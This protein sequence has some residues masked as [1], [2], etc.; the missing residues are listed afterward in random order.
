MAILSYRW[1]YWSI[2]F[3]CSPW[4]TS[5]TPVIGTGRGG[6]WRCRWCICSGWSERLHCLPISLLFSLLDPSRF[7][8]LDCCPGCK[9]LPHSVREC[10]L[11]PWSSVAAEHHWG[12]HLNPRRSHLL[13]SLYTAH[14][15]RQLSGPA[16][17][18]TSFQTCHYSFSCS[19]ICLIF[20][21]LCFSLRLQCRGHPCH[22][23]ACYIMITNPQKSLG[24]MTTSRS[25]RITI[26]ACTPAHEAPWTT[27]A[28]GPARLLYGYQDCTPAISGSNLVLLRWHGVSAW[29]CQ[30]LRQQ[31]NWIP[32]ASHTS[33][34]YQEVSYQAT[35][36]YYVFCV[37][38][39]LHHFLGKEEIEKWLQTARIQH[40]TDPSYSRSS[41]PSA[42]IL[43]LYTTSWKYIR[44]MAILNIYLCMTQNQP[45]SHDLHSTKYSLAWY[46]Y[47]R[48]HSYA[49]DQWIW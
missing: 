34:N 18:S 48:C 36:E 16:A 32:C 15:S 45:V 41:H 31:G 2:C 9:H 30:F 47:E 14:Y 25:R 8:W 37:L 21:D 12:T 33:G 23:S 35:Q 27:D 49:Y 20:S 4:K 29:W 26:S 17:S 42:G 13:A 28:W 6:C 10:C 38:D 19:N 43:G 3:C 7:R 1:G 11:H 5:E 39:Q 44:C 46:L 24:P 40:P 22:P